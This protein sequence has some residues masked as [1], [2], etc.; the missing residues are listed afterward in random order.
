MRI[1]LGIITVLALLIF[2]SFPVIVGDLSESS[3]LSKSLLTIFAVSG[4]FLFARLWV[5]IDS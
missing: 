4:C 1:A 3:L 5:E 2:I